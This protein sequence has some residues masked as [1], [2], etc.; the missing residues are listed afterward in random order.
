MFNKKE[1]CQKIE[2]LYNTY[3]RLMY[4]EAFDIL[5]EKGLAEDAVHQSFV[6]ILKYRDDIGEIED[7]K[8]KNFL[9]VVCRNSAINLYNQ[10]KKDDK[11]YL[12]DDKNVDKED[13]TGIVIDHESVRK[14]VGAIEELPVIYRDTLLLEKVHGYNANEISELL[15]IS[16]EAVYK[17]SSR[18]RNL[19]IKALKDNK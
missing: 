18:A 10:N 6:K 14:V 2:L 3:K 5:K 8:T 12:D 19:L 9:M 1:K 17:R 11:I 15:D 7:I 13:T 4:K 16:V